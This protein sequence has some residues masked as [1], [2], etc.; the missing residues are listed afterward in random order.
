M[1]TDRDLP[2]GLSALVARAVLTVPGVAFLRPG[3]SA[4]LRASAPGLVRG[5]SGR[6]AG[7]APG[8][9]FE[10]GAAGGVVAAEVEVVVHRGHRAVDVTRAVR[11]AV[12]TALGTPGRVAAPAPTPL[13]VS[14]PVRVKVTVTGIV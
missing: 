14:A 6:D 11:E 9:R 3:L 13:P 2:E 12:R 1:T 8:V 7:A 5:G 10:R 4:L